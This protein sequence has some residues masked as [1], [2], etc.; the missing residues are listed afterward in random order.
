[1]Q[2]NCKTIV[3]TIP[4]RLLQWQ[5]NLFIIQLSTQTINYQLTVHQFSIK[6]TD[7]AFFALPKN[8]FLRW[9]NFEKHCNWISYQFSLIRRKFPSMTLISASHVWYVILLAMLCY[10]DIDA[11]KKKKLTSITYMRY[12]FKNY[13]SSVSKKKTIWSNFVN[14]V[15]KTVVAKPTGF[16]CESL[17]AP[18]MESSSCFQ[19][20]W[21]IPRTL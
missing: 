21:K 8:I 7:F 4:N 2:D 14:A 12:L 19:A 16:D 6:R 13:K 1:M 9:R 18:T 15:S 11:I 20:Q 5:P 17:F 10:A 3:K